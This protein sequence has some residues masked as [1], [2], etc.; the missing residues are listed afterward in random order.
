MLFVS[1]FLAILLIIAIIMKIFYVEGLIPSIIIFVLGFLTVITTSIASTY[2]VPVKNVGLVISFGKPTG[3]TTGPGLHMIA[4]WKSISDWDASR[5]TYDQQ[6]PVRI[7]TQANADVSINIQWQTLPSAAP[8]Q[9]G[10]FKGQFSEFVRNGV[11]IYL[12]SAVIKAFEVYNPLTTIDTKSDTP[13]LDY[14]KYELAVMLLA[15]AALKDQ[16]EILSVSITGISHDQKT[17]EAIKKF[18]EAVAESRILEQARKNA[19]VRKQVTE[20]NASVDKVTRCLEIAEKSGTEPGWC[21]NP[22]INISK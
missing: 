16:V 1:I 11:N 3:E 17:E 9:F 21:I 22:G 19:M 10:A 5:Q 14:E 6:V 2:V 4:P 13:A 8:T 15:K 20:T 12:A 18:Q 7:A